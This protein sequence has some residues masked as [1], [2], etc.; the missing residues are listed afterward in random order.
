M[1]DAA[2]HPSHFT[3]VPEL[4]PVFQRRQPVAAPELLHEVAGLVVADRFADFADREVGA[5]D[6]VFGQKEPMLGDV[7]HR[8]C[9]SVLLEQCRAAVFVD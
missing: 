3:A 6:Q 2:E 8:G 9:L 4:L 7:F 1:T 5:D